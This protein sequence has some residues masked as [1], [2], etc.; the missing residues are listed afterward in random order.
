MT[1]RHILAVL[2]ITA[3]TAIFIVS[4]LELYEHRAIQVAREHLSW[5]RLEQTDM[6]LAEAINQVPTSPRLRQEWSKVLTALGRWRNDP[7]AA[8][9]ARMELAAAVSLN[10]LDGMAWGEY[11]ES[12]RRSGEPEAAVAALARGLERDPNNIYLL[13]LLGQAQQEAGRPA[14]AVVTFERAQSIRSTGPV[15]RLLQQV[16]AQLAE[17]AAK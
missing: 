4:A 14:E 9:Q 11:G 16:K 13:G 2:A 15:S 3:G 8:A 17:E 6:V 5:G 7:G 1:Q 12:L 10:P